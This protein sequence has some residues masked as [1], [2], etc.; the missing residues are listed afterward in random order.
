MTWIS[1]IAIKCTVAAVSAGFRIEQRMDF[2]T[3]TLKI[4]FISIIITIT[5]YYT[6]AE[7][8]GTMPA[9]AHAKPMVCETPQFC[10]QMPLGKQI[11]HRNLRQSTQHRFAVCL[12]HSPGRGTQGTPLQQHIADWRSDC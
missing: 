12:R 11:C 7:G 4:V 6:I 3:W 9:R 5:Y 1:D 2:L 8:Q 10:C